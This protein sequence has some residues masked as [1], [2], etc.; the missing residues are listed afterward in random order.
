MLTANA[1]LNNAFVQS[2]VTV[3]GTTSAVPQNITYD[4]IALYLVINKGVT[5]TNETFYGMLNKGTTALPYQPYFTGLRDSKVTAVESV[6]ANVYC[7]TETTKHSTGGIA[8]EWDKD[9]QI[10]AITA[11]VTAAA[12]VFLSLKNALNIVGG[13]VYS[14]SAEKLAD[15]S[16]VSLAI[17]VCDSRKKYDTAGGYNCLGNIS[18]PKTYIFANDARVDTIHIF[19][20]GSGTV[21]AKFKYMINKGPTALPYSPYFRESLPIPADALDGFG[22][23]VNAQYCNKIVIDPL[24]GVKKYVKKVGVLDMGLQGWQYSSADKRFFIQDARMAK[25]S[26]NEAMNALCAGYTPISF[27]DFYADSTRDKTISRTGDYLFVRNLSY[28]SAAAFKTAMSGV[29]LLYELATPTETDVSTLFA[30]DN[31]LPV[32]AG[33]TITA[34]NEYEQAVPFSIEYTVKG[35]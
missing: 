18:T 34:V 25:S 31:L 9:E 1:M 29:V 30:D 2:L 4:K 6:G 21:N 33:G 32:E 8:Y 28:T 11:N 16:N 14:M 5:L 35:A 26:N 27:N 3:Q 19:I 17:G 13:E 7:G 22:Q 24:E 15:T 10:I 20:N 12:E 23:G